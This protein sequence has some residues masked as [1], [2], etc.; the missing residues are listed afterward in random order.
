MKRVLCP[1]LPVP[2]Q[3]VV[4]PESEAIHL[5]RVFR[6]SDGDRVEALDGRGNSV[7][8]ILR[9]EHGQ[10]KLEYQAPGDAQK[11][12]PLT[13]EMAVLK[14][15][16]MEWLVEKAVE[17]GVKNLIPVLTAH[18][19]VQMKN[20][21]PEAFRERWQK[22]ADQSLKQCGRTTRLEIAL[23]IELESLLSEKKASAESVRL[24]CDEKSSGQAAELS[25]WLKERNPL[26]GLSLLIGPE[27]GWSEIERALLSRESGENMVRI[28]LGP[29]VLRAET[30]ALFAVALA[31]AALRHNGYTETA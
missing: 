11:L 20:K 4:I 19:I 10:A 8:A 24:W 1:K 27:G 25:E 2:G 12:L 23:P 29:L 18:T 7:H 22:I 30:A 14:G 26:T 9:V 3:K 6:L 13:L 16:A 15:D 28:D 31:V 21:G 17:L 5:T